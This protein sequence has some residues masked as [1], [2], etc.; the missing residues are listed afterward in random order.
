MTKTRINKLVA[1]FLAVVMTIAF[2]IYMP[3]EKANAL[4][5]R[6]DYFDR[7]YTLG[8]DPGQNMVNIAFAQKGKTGAQLNY[9]EAWCADF[10]SDCAKL[11]GQS[12]VI[13]HRAVVRDLANAVNGN[14]TS[15]PRVGDL[16]I[17]DW[18]SVSGP[19][20]HIEIVY[21]VSGSTVYTIGGNTGSTGNCR[22][23][24]VKTRN[25]TATG[26][27]QCYIHP[28]YS[29]SVDPPKPDSPTWATLETQDNRTV[30]GISEQVQFKMNSD[31]AK[32]YVIGIDYEGERIVTS[33][34]A[35]GYD[36]YCYGFNF[37]GNYTAY[38]SA[39]NGN[40]H[41]ESN[42][43]NFKV[44]SF[45]NKLIF[46][47]NGG[48][49]ATLD[50]KLIY[51]NS[52]GELPTPTKTGCTFEG[53]YTEKSGGTKITSDTIVNVTSDQTLYAHWKRISYEVYFDANGGTSDAVCLSIFYN[54]TYDELASASR[55]GYKFLGWYTKK[56]GGT[57]VTNETV[58]KLT[59]DQTL[60][61]HWEKI[62]VKGD[63]NADGKFN[64]SDAVLLQ[65]WLLAVPNTNLAD[66]KA[67]DLCEDDRLDVFDLC[68]MKRML[69]ENS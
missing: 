58:Y 30:F 34:M 36:L 9:S 22:T 68:M 31:N 46:D 37:T 60:Y 50:K 47:S 42:I 18:N 24:Y 59:T 56:E 52:Y 38:V 23:N 55:D 2:G 21:Q 28:N 54:S 44:V 16:C 41:I 43:V 19:Y 57:L 6:T 11:A 8:S 39:Y 15:S 29:G 27:V 67:A 35:E 65:N 10:V 3:P 14:V 32:Y 20:D 51:N 48:S 1:A 49:C 26:Q 13:P 12:N 7:S 69:V 63:I 53:W 45:E 40:N 62:N 64:V 33:P 4:Q 17:F 25:A 66:W 5:S 61:A